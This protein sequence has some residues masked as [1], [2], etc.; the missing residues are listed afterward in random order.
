M[1]EPLLDPATL[2]IPGRQF[3]DQNGNALE[4]LPF[5]TGYAIS[6]DGWEMIAT[7]CVRGTCAPEGLSS[8]SADSQTGLFRS[9]DGG[10]TW[11]E[12][13]RLNFGASVFALLPDGRALLNTYDSKDSASVR[14]YPG[15]AELN[16][17]VGLGYWG[18]S[19]VVL[20]DGQLVLRNDHGVPIRSD[21]H[22][23][24]AIP[25]TESATVIT[26]F[27]IDRDRLDG[28]ALVSGI[29][30]R[31]LV[32]FDSNGAIG[33]GAFALGGESVVWSGNP[34][35][36]GVQLVNEGLILANASVPSSEPPPPGQSPIFDYRPV[37][38]D[39]QRGV[40]H[41]LRQ[42]SGP[43]YRTGRNHIVA[44]QRGPF[45]RV[46]NTDDT[47][48]YIR[49]EPLPSAGILDCAAEGVLLTDIGLAKDFAGSTWLH[50]ATPAGAEGWANAQYLER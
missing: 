17:P 15:L 22:P 2:G 30:T 11:T 36:F 31:Y 24:V 8:W 23:L 1:Q 14:A 16:F 25:P 27:V 44:A 20:A 45:A 29:G 47:C 9:L 18:G 46:V 33:R 6:Q 41:L 43:E 32:P 19:V 12:T 39:F 10:I 49:A 4:Y 7:I 48:V 40:M 50:V 13:E 42:F 38:I 3:T 26:D 37:G 28:L 5:I 21:G 35:R 34:D